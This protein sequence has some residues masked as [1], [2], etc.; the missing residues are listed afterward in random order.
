MLADEVEAVAVTHRQPQAAAA[1]TNQEDEG[2]L[3]ARTRRHWIIQKNQ[4]TP[5]QP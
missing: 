1:A 2:H 4:Q 5:I 3:E